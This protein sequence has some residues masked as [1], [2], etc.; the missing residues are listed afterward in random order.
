LIVQSG[1][2]GTATRLAVELLDDLHGWTGAKRVIT[3][4]VIE[5]LRTRTADLLNLRTLN[6]NSLPCYR[7][8]YRYGLTI[9]T[10]PI[11]SAVSQIVSRRMAKKGQMRWSR[12]GA[13]RLLDVRTQMLN[14]TLE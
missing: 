4:V 2:S 13:Q 10:A 1:I 6:S 11:E 9:S 12:D 14:G 3:P 8:R 7:L 5:K